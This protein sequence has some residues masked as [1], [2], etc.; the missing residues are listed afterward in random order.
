ME[1]VGSNLI[2]AHNNSFKMFYFVGHSRVNASGVKK[3]KK[4]NVISDRKILDDK[5]ILLQHLTHKAKGS[6]QKSSIEI[7]YR[8]F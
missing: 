2:L 1:I 7:F 4:K 3:N 6:K 8:Y 5:T